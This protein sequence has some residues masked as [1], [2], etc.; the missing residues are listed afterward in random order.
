VH[1]AD[2]GTTALHT[3]AYTGRAD[4]VRLLIAAGA[5]LEA[6]DTAFDST[7]LSWATVG[8][9]NPPRHGHDGDWVVTIQAL[10]DA[11]ANP[12]GAWVTAKPPSDQVAALLFAHGIHPA[13]SDEIPA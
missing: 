4:L 13:G 2:D 1:R 11:G 6:R 7:P 5:D 12:D 3:A 8:S 9:G 10:L